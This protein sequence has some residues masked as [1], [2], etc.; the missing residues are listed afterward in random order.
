[1]KNK[2]DNFSKWKASNHVSSLVTIVLTCFVKFVFHIKNGR[3]WRY[4]EKKAKCMQINF[5]FFFILE[6][7]LHSSN[8]EVLKIVCKSFRL[9]W[10]KSA[11]LFSQVGVLSKIVQIWLTHHLDYPCLVDGRAKS[12]GSRGKVAG[13]ARCNNCPQ[14]QTRGPLDQ[15]VG[16]HEGFS[17]KVRVEHAEVHILETWK[18][19][20]ERA[21]AKGRLCPFCLKWVCFCVLWS[22]SGVTILMGALEAF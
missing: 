9:K 14:D 18:C 20:L 4:L 22:H 13:P 2:F 19:S 5:S 17:F 1:M 12:Q 8:E 3:C 6:S 16:K 10:K 21:V 15:T 11:N 7:L